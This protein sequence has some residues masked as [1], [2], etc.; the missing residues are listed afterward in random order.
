[1]TLCPEPAEIEA[2]EIRKSHNSTISLHCLF[3]IV[4]MIHEIK[5]K[6]VFDTEAL[7]IYDNH[8]NDM[9]K[10]SRRAN[11]FDSFLG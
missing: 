2:D 4:Q 1:M 9:K 3:L 6:Y 11:T 8:F 7:Q 10:Y 5:R